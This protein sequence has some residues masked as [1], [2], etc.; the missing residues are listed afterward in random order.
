MPDP[1]LSAAEE[2]ALESAA[3]R[4]YVAYATTHAAGLFQ[5]PSASPWTAEVAAKDYDRNCA[6]PLSGPGFRRLWRAVAAAVLN[7]PEP[8]A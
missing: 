5:P 8:A 3:R 6:M 2:P 1:E 7:P 4:A